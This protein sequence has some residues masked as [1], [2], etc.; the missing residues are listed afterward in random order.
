MRIWKIHEDRKII[1][2]IDQG[3]PPKQVATS[4]GVSVWVVYK[5]MHRFT[6]YKKNIS[7]GKK[8]L[9]TGKP[10]NAEKNNFIDGN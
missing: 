2:L 7:M 8:C 9:P 6:R 3:F 5:A 4:V 10:V 1:E